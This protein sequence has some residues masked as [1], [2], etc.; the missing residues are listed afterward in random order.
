M[1][2]EAAQARA[3]AKVIGEMWKQRY[4]RWVNRHVHR[5]PLARLRLRGARANPY[6]DYALMRERGPMFRLRTGE[7]VTADHAIAR[8]VLRDR[9]F[10]TR[11]AGDPGPT[12][13]PQEMVLDMGFLERDPPD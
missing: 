12:E 7:R 1:A 6:P 4:T 5:D 8:E 11:L 3:A 2:G 9:R 10:G 13:R